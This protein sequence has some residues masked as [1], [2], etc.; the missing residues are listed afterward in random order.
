MPLFQI[1]RSL[2]SSIGTGIAPGINAGS[3]F[4]QGRSLDY[5]YPLNWMIE[6]Q[7][8]NEG[9]SKQL[10]DLRDKGLVERLARDINGSSAKEGNTDCVQLMLCK[11]AP[12]VWGMQKAVFNRE[13]IG[14]VDGGEEKEKT[15]GNRLDSYF[16]HLPEVDEFKHHGDVCEERYTKCKVFP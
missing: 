3:L 2:M 5:N 7:S 6:N 4:P 13:D 16:K 10:S 15:Q 8:G 12:I 9:V 11:V 1:G 14:G